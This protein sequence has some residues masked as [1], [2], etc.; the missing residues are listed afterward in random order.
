MLGNKDLTIKI[1]TILCVH[2]LGG[3]FKNGV[4]QYAIRI[5]LHK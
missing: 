2:T 4:I 5:A 1:P 3:I